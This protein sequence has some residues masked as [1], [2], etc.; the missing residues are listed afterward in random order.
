METLRHLLPDIP[1][2]AVDVARLAAW[3]LVLALV[4]IPLERISALRRQPVW[5]A[6]I[7]TDLAY[8]FLSGILPKLLLVLPMTFLAWSLHGV[9]PA[10]LHAWVAGLP[11]GVRLAGALVVGEIGFYW[12]HRWSHE[13]PLLWRFHSIHHS[14]EH[15]DWLVNT[16]AHPI[17]MMFSRLCGFVPMYVLGFAQPMIQD[18]LDPVPVLVLLIGGCWGYFIHANLRWRFG[19]LENLIATP[20]FHHWHHTNDAR[21]DRNYASMLP[22]MD[23]I[24]GTYHVPATEWPGVYGIDQKLA[25]SLAGQLIDPLLPARNRRPVAAPA[26]AAEG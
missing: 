11:F 26:Q 19:W 7:A 18:R 23:R 17:D 15:L 25:P 12:G 16:R 20:A 9:V 24:F 8:Y 2:L 14:A 4:F 6:G 13:I 1:T 10:G 5:R 22:W 21:R 3:L